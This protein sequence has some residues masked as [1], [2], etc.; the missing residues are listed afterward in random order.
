MLLEGKRIIVTGGMSGIGR[1]T[2]LAC[3][4]DGARVVSFSSAA[5]ERTRVRA[6]LK[7]A[8]EI[9]RG[10]AMHLQVDV[11]DQEQVNR[12]FERAVEWLGGLDGLVNSAATQAQKPAEMFTTEDIM[13]DVSVNAF[14]TVYTNQASFRY[15]KDTGGSIVN[16]TSYVA[17]GGQDQMASYGLAKGAVIG[18]SHVVAK[19]WGRYFIR[20]NMVA[21]IVETEG[22]RNFYQQLSP[23][24]QLLSDQKRAATIALGGKLGTAGDAANV[25]VFL[26]SDLSKYMTGQ[27][28]YADGGVS[29]AR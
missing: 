27:I 26:V 5:P 8:Q 7:E 25:I 9:G 1:A 21:P 18:W 28:L 12:G 22:F 14:G 23:E 13:R 15:L 29:F 20:V 2:V 19:E 4:K 11:S 17:I 24:G 16:M 3:V 10:D 6:T